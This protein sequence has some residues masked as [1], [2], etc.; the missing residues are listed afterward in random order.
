M[1]LADKQIRLDRI[2]A[3]L[4]DNDVHMYDHPDLPSAEY[5]AMYGSVFLAGP[6]SRECI[7][8]YNWR[9]DAVYYLRKQGFKGVIFVPEPGKAG[10]AHSGDFT[11]KEF[12][13]SWEST[14]LLSATYVVFWIPRNKHELLGLNTNLEFGIWLGK[15]SHLPQEERVRK[16]FI[17]W[18]DTAERMGLPRH[19]AADHPV[20]GGYHIH[21]D[22]EHLCEAVQMTHTHRTT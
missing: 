5:G 15:L 9:S 2:S 18:P 10:I 8:E 6:T 20:T 19:Y 3:M 14:R 7:A 17:G 11:E 4:A 13:H 21:G 12:I 16:L 1:I 22:L